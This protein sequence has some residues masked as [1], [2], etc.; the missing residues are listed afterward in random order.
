M[1]IT[2]MALAAFHLLLR[3]HKNP[4]SHS[5]NIN[6]GSAW[7]SSQGWMLGKENWWLKVTKMNQVRSKEQE[8]GQDALMA[9]DKGG[10]EGPTELGLP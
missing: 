5:T 7:R 1:I 6:R 3:G 2:P 9:M 4:I 8:L 10:A